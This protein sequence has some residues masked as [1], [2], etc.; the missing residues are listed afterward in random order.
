MA[1]WPENFSECVCVCE[2]VLAEKGMEIEK[3]K[4]KALLLLICV[5]T[6]LQLLPPIPP[7]THCQ[8]LRLFLRCFSCFWRLIRLFFVRKNGEQ[9]TRMR[10]RIRI[11][12]RTV[13][14]NRNQNQNTDEHCFRFRLS[15]WLMVKRMDWGLGPHS[16]AVSDC[17]TLCGFICKSSE[18]SQPED[19]F[20]AE[21]TR[22]SPNRKVKAKVTA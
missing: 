12:M 5:F 2:C 13:D 4:W 18:T 21:L 7:T 11:R 20:L 19:S 17:R 10:M 16:F 15:S 14:R 22:R 9:K 3:T 6:C 8:P 1:I